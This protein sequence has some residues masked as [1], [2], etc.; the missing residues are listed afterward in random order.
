MN[1]WFWDYRDSN[2]PRMYGSW[3]S[4]KVNNHQNTLKH[5][6]FEE[7]A[8]NKDKT[9]ADKLVYIPYK[10]K[11]NNSFCKSKPLEEKFEKNYSIQDS[12]K[13]P[14]VFSQRMRKWLIKLWNI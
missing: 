10:K 5:D 2:R 9:M 7:D 8:I 14:I 12:I 4:T 1:M 13:I 6:L 3:K 11:V